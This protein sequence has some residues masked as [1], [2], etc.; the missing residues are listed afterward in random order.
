ML[1]VRRGLSI[2]WIVFAV[3]L[4]CISAFPRLLSFIPVTVGGILFMVGLAALTVVIELRCR[5]VQGMR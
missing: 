5:Y 1:R 2:F 3:S 4:F